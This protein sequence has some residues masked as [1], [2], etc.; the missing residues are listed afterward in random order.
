M[1][2]DEPQAGRAGRN[3]AATDRF[4]PLRILTRH[5]DAT[6]F[7]DH[8][9]QSAKDALRELIELW[10]ALKDAIDNQ[11]EDVRNA[12]SDAYRLHPLYA[13]YFPDDHAAAVA[14]VEGASH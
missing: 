6:D 9:E 10:E 12:I 13:K 7:D 4:D 2:N 3:S 11:G 5:A 14:E 8:P 1:P